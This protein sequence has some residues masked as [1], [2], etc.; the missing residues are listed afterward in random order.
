MGVHIAVVGNGRIGRP[1]AYT[2]FNE[3]LADEISLVDVKPGLSWAFGEEL[4][5]AAASLRYDVEINTYE[6][7]EGVSGADL[8]VVC[9]GKPRTPGVQMSRRDLVAENARIVHYVAEV[10]PPRSPGAKWVIVTNPVDA[11]ATLFKKVSRERFVIGTGDHPDTLRFRAKLA[12]DLGVPVSSVDGFV[13]GEHGSAA[14]GLWSTVK[15]GGT[16]LDEYLRGTGKTLDREA[17]IRYVRTVSKRIVDSVGGT[18]YGPA[19]GFRDIVRS[20]LQDRGEVYSVA[21][22]TRLPG[23]P[24]PVN[25]N[26][27]THVGESLGPSLW[28]ELTAEEQGNIIDAAKA[29]YANY[30]T[31]IEAVETARTLNRRDD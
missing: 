26:I 25:V 16:P 19:A 14:H 13:G 29:I 28:D 3:R 15:I 17:V 30:L 24:E 9:V 20:I 6:E 22:S 2:L 1:T 23:L 11:M 12:M 7:D 4:R 8:V 18:E 21:D 31:G 5:H 27:P 10:M